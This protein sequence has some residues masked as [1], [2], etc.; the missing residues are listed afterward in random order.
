[1]TRFP[2]AVVTA[3]V[4]VL[5]AAGA[6]VVATPSAA[7]ECQAKAS[8]RGATVC[9]TQREDGTFTFRLTGFKPESRY[10]WRAN[11]FSY[12]VSGLRV[13]SEGTTDHATG[14]L[15]PRLRAAAVQNELTVTGIAKDGSRVRL[16]LRRL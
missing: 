15:P 9:L 8:S 16:R 12:G 1:M 5:L 7:R 14:L 3:S 2:T 6:A 10:S 13:D 11:C 4:V